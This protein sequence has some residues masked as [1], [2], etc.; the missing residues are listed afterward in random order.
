MDGPAPRSKPTGHRVNQR[1]MSSVEEAIDL[2]AAP[3]QLHDH[4]RVH[5]RGDSPYCLA[6]D[7]FAVSAFDE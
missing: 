5:G 4:T 3:P 1:G 6:R 2:P 7:S